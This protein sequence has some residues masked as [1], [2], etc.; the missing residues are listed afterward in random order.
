MSIHFEKE[1]FASRHN[2]SDNAAT[3]E[4]LETVKAENLDQLIDETIPKEIRLAH[5]LELPEALSEV[6][7]LANSKN[8]HRRIKCINHLSGWGIMILMCRM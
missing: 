6:E 7:F 3:K 2:G 4:M 8:W 1:L 5:N